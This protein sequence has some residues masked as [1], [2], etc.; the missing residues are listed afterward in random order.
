MNKYISQFRKFL[1]EWN[2]MM[3]KPL[4]NTITLSQIDK[5]FFR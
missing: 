2:V 4:G 5:N 1:T 3:P